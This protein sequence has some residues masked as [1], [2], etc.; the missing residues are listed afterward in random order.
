MCDVT[1]PFG[2]GFQA[3][4]DSCFAA[5]PV[6]RVFVPRVVGPH[7]MTM[8]EVESSTEAS[9]F[10]LN[11]CVG[12]IV[13]LLLPAR[14]RNVYHACMAIMWKIREPPITTSRGDPRATILGLLEDDHGEDLA[15]ILIVV[16]GVGF[17]A[18]G[19]RLGYGGGF[20]GAWHGYIHSFLRIFDKA[21][22]RYVLGAIESCVPGK[23]PGH[24]DH[25]TP[26][27]C[28]LHELCD[29]LTSHCVFTSGRVLQ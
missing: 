29:S 23:C 4:I 5:E 3:I 10:P 8:Y 17:D 16:P 28:C 22:R 15:P 19:R 24:H 1:H 14:A 25:C 18:T 20:Y 21:L 9:T 2:C 26:L 12:R 6:K 27:R 7:M 11:K 13:R